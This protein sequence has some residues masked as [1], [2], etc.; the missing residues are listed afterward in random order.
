MT[1]NH[2]KLRSPP[3]RT[4]SHSQST[5]SISAGCMLSLPC[6]LLA[7]RAPRMLLLALRHSIAAVGRRSRHAGEQALPLLLL[8]LCYEL[9]R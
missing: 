4:K 5:G 2:L 7:C 1:A 6:P 8:P 3:V 9:L